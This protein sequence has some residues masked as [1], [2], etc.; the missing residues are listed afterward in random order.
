MNQVL[1]LINERTPIPIFF[2]K[3]RIVGLVFFILLFFTQHVLP[4]ETDQQGSVPD[5]QKGYTAEMQLRQTL[6]SFIYG[7]EFPYSRYNASDN[8]QGTLSWHARSFRQMSPEYTYTPK[9]VPDGQLNYQANSTWQDD[10]SEESCNFYTIVGTESGLVSGTVRADYLLYVPPTH[11]ANTEM[12]YGVYP[13]EYVNYT[14]LSDYD[15][16]S[17][18]FSSERQNEISPVHY[19]IYLKNHNCPIQEI[20]DYDG[21][22]SLR[23]IN[24]DL[25][26]YPQRDQVEFI[27]FEQ[28]I[29]EMPSDSTIVN[30]LYS[31]E[32]RGRYPIPIKRERVNNNLVYSEYL[33]N[34]FY[35]KWGAY[36]ASGFFDSEDQK[37]KLWYGAGTPEH[38]SSDNI[39]YTE[40]TDLNRPWSKPQRLTTDHSTRHTLIDPT[41]KLRAHNEQI[42]YGGDPSVIKVNGTYYLYFSG[43]EKELNDGRYTHWNKIYVATSENGQN[44]TVAGIPV[45]C[46]TG[47]SLGYG[48]GSPSAVYRDGTFYLYYYTQAPDARYPDEPTGLVLK[49]SRDGIHFDQGISIHRGMGAMDVKYIPS[50]NIWAGTYY[51]EAGQFHPDTKA[52][53]R[54]A[55]SEDGFSWNF[56]CSD[57][58]LIAQNMNYPLNHNPGFIG[59]ELGHGYETMFLTFG[60]N[61]LPLTLNGYW[62]SAAQYDARQLFWSRVTIAK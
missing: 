33:G 4:V 50:L 9:T 15:T 40:T 31:I 44:W 8:T 61:D 14:D 5:P 59:N 41:G 10:F 58:S 39:Y 25:T 27:R 19:K 30:K 12:N 6:A 43:L 47:G 62:F 45:D 11:P 57:K 56:D 42:G 35:T 32:A 21:S 34:L 60:A 7:P 20:E 46:A 13:A 17:I 28:I 29:T 55:F 23:E 2:K 16:L 26:G 1:I 53:I 38:G 37:W 52:G 51:T 24:I 3:Y 54:V 22:G 36:S 49:K 48:A 18:K